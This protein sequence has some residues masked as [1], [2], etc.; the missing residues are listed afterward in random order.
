MS[1]I[2]NFVQRGTDTMLGLSKV[3]PVSPVS[4]GPCVQPI[5]FWNGAALHRLRRH[6]TLF[7]TWYLCVPKGAEL[8]SLR[9]GLFAPLPA[10]FRRLWPPLIDCRLVA[11]H[12]TCKCNRLN[13]LCHKKGLFHGMLHSYATPLARDAIDVEALRYSVL[14][15]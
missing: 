7:A 4:H 15:C 10:G 2:S 13:G 1:D 11:C 12:L 6:P 3:S 14:E 5:T 8:T 9:G